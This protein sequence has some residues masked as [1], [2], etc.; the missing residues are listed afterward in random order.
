[1]ILTTIHTV[2]CTRHYSYK[3]A[4]RYTHTPKYICTCLC[5]LGVWY[6]HMQITPAYT[7]TLHQPLD[8]TKDSLIRVSYEQ[9]TKSSTETYNYKWN[10]ALSIIVDIGAPLN[11]WSYHASWCCNMSFHF[12]SYFVLNFCVSFLVF[13]YL[14]HTNQWTNKWK[15]FART[16]WL[17]ML[18]NLKSSIELKNIKKLYLPLL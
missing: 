18:L 14:N 3:I 17:T 1:M 7:L 10:N 11:C 4:Y 5:K 16:Y 13:S 15:S 12:C 9:S 6:I 2:K 8:H